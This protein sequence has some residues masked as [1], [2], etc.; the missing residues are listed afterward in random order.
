MVMA[1]LKT[2]MYMRVYTHTWGGRC[3]ATQLRQNRQNPKCGQF[4]FGGHSCLKDPSS[5]VRI[6]PLVKV[7]VHHV[8]V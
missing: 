2:H 8:N 4:L 5:S 3:R 1:Q 6:F 7:S